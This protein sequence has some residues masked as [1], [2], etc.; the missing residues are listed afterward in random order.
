MSEAEHSLLAKVRVTNLEA[1]TLRLSGF[2]ET[3]RQ[4]YAKLRYASMPAG[5]R[6]M[7]YLSS[8]HRM[9]RIKSWI[10]VIAA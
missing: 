7:G 10:V 2:P 6:R 5:L 9:M 4:R 1:I 8:I 3:P